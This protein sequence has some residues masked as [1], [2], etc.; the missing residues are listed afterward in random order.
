MRLVCKDWYN[1]CTDL[2]PVCYTWRLQIHPTDVDINTNQDIYNSVSFAHNITIMVDNSVDKSAPISQRFVA[3]VKMTGLLSNLMENLREQHADSRL[4]SLHIKE[5]ILERLDIQLPQLPPL[6]SLIKLQID[7]D[8]RWDIVHLFTIL[9]ACPNLHELSVKPSHVAASAPQHTLNSAPQLSEI[10]AAQELAMAST[11]STLPTMSQL[12][13]CSLYNL[14]ITLPALDMFLQACSHLKK[15]VLARC[16]LIVR[17]GQDPALI[18]SIS[19]HPNQGTIITG[20]VGTHCPDLTTFHLSMARGGSYGLESRELV[21]VLDTFPQ[22][23]EFNFAAQEMRPN[24]YRAFSTAVVNRIT[25]LNLLPVQPQTVSTRGIPLRQILC[26]FEHLIHLR[27]PTAVYYHEDMDLNDVKGQLRD[28][29]IRPDCSSGRSDP[30][31]PTDDPAKVH[32][33]IWACRGLKTLHMTIDITGSDSGSPVTSLIIF[34]FLSRMCPQLEEL[35]LKRWN[36]NLK[37]YGGFSLL[38]RLQQLERVR[39]VMEYHSR[40]DEA[41]LLWI[42]PDPPSIWDRF[43]YPIL[44]HQI[45]NR[46]ERVYDGVS[47]AEG[48]MT[49]SKLVERGHELGMDLSKIGY[50]EDLL[51]WMDAR[52]RTTATTAATTAPHPRETLRNLPNLELL[53]IECAKPGGKGSAQRLKTHVDKIRPVVHFQMNKEPKDDFFYTTLQQY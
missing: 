14:I 18:E 8:A 41:A 45:V 47:L 11:P 4:E 19:N 17:R 13:V 44:R 23:D 12:Q 16:S 49:G 1:I 53:W 3:W 34:G 26:T 33:Y 36:L 50:P 22:V 52:Y 6:N 43:V 2:A 37:L 10:T 42:H 27:A 30:R 9:S 31:I 32:Q 25:T 39:I 40:M 35:Y 20:R 51:E 7:V 28:R 5:G 48:T 46:L 38:A 29:K 21:F 24:L 15:L